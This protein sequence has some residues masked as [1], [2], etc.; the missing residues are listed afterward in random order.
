MKKHHYQVEYVHDLY[1]LQKTIDR[2]NEKGWTII[3]VTERH[4]Y[5]IIYDCEVEDC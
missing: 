3:S 4:G 2:I 5:T 1:W